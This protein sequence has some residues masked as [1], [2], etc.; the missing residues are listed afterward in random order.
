MGLVTLPVGVLALWGTALASGVAG[1]VALAY[2]LSD[3]S[4]LV[5]AFGRGAAAGVVFWSVEALAL[6]ARTAAQASAMDRL[7]LPAA[8]LA[9]VAVVD[10]GLVTSGVARPWLLNLLWVMAV[11][12]LLAALAMPRAA[13]LFPVTRV[14]DGFYLVDGGRARWVEVVRVCLATCCFVALAAWAVRSLVVARDRRWLW[15]GAALLLAVPVAFNDTLWV[16]THETPFPLSWMVGVSALVIFWR[17]LR[18]EIQSTYALLNRDQTTGA[19]SRSHGDLYGARCLRSGA[20]GTVY[21]DVDDFKS[22]N[23]S[24]GHASGDAFLGEIVRRLTAASR[25]LDAVVRMGGDE[26]LVV[27]PGCVESDGPALVARLREAV[28]GEPILVGSHGGSPPSALTPHV[29]M[30][31]AWAERGGD[32]AALVARADESMYR[33]KREHRLSALAGGG[34]SGSEGRG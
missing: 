30:G 3:G 16:R 19:R 7:Y 9:L 12:L 34:L 6:G 24:F 32:F 11:A 28:C 14:P 21:V 25:P 13:A 15:Y 33:E 10:C 2:W 5:A 18:N 1:L 23:D 27:M 17:E 29:S 22:V 31:F 20:V 8:F 26:L 4:P